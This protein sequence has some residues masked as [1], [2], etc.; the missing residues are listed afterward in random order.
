MSAEEVKQVWLSTLTWEEAVEYAKKHIIYVRTSQFNIARVAHKVCTPGTGGRTP[1]D[2]YTYTR[3]ARE[4]GINR[5]TL[6]EWVRLYE[7]VIL[8]SDLKNKES[9]TS[10]DYSTARKAIACKSFRERNGIQV[11]NRSMKRMVRTA[12]RNKD[13]QT[14]Y[15]SSFKALKSVR[16]MLGH[17]AKQGIKQMDEGVKN[18]LRVLCKQV[19]KIIGE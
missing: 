15:N 5:D 10:Q 4:V 7:T 19:L 6:L 18:E 2:Q 11:D 1:K 12:Q 9:F 8:N 16:L 17:I 14:V 13:D 3:F